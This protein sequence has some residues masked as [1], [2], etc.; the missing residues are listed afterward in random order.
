ML[1][2]FIFLDCVSHSSFPQLFDVNPSYGA[3]QKIDFRNKRS[4]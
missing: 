1:E 4:W 2:V 3:V